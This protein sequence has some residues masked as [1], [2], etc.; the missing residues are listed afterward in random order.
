MKFCSQCG[1]HVREE[2]PDGEDRL[3]SVCSG[4]G[5]IHYVNPKTVVGWML[6]DKLEARFQLQVHKHIWDAKTR[7]V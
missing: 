3:R 6:E 5:T 1:A 4:C 2:I 7:S